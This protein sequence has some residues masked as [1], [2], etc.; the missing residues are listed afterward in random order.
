MT[1][2]KTHHIRAAA[3]PLAITWRNPMGLIL[4][5]PRLREASNVYYGWRE[6]ATRIRARRANWDATRNWEA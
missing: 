1:I 5:K 4:A 3:L 2:H 6:Q